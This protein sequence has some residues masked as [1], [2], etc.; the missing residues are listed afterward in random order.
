MTFK[1]GES[2]SRIDLSVRQ[3]LH[4]VSSI[5]RGGAVI[6]TS[7]WRADQRDFTDG[8]FAGS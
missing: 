4:N 6:L 2:A 3:V 5:A 7:V 1:L 8:V